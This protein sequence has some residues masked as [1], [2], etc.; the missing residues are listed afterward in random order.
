MN[1]SSAQL[2]TKVF[3]CIAAFAAWVAPSVPVQAG[4]HEVTVK[5]PVSY[6]GLDLSQPADVR[7]LYHRLQNAAYIACTGGNR[8]D[9][10]PLLVPT[11]CIEK[12]IGDAVRSAKQPQLTMI[13]LKTHTSKEAAT[14]GIDVSILVAAQ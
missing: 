12:A 10:E 4:D 9:L 13:Y 8:V 2:T 6:V 5:I 1:V 3:A 11:A 14:H 7:E